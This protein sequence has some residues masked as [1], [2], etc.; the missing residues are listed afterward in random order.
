MRKL[1]GLRSEI[2]A[3]EG[4]D[5]QARAAEEL[6]ELSELEGDASLQESLAEEVATIR[7][8]LEDLEFKLVLS[9]RFDRKDAIIAIHAGA[10]GVESQDWVGMLMRMY[11]RWAENRGY[12]SDVMDISHGEEGGV[13]SAVVAYRAIT[14]T[15][16]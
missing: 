15:A 6:L 12:K 16:T 8:T 1:A 3:W 2:D 5:R 7:D 9:G 11:L 4:L 13:K 10:G 14:P